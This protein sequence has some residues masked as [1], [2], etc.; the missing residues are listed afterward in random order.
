MTPENPAPI[1]SLS[2]LVVEDNAFAARVLE[3][4]LK[5]L[6]AEHVHLAR[7]GREGL[8]LAA[9]LSPPPDVILLDLRMPEMG[10]VELLTRLGDRRYPG[11][12]IVTSGVDEETLDS[13]D[14][15]ARERS[16]RLLG[17]LQKPV[18][19]ESLSRLLASMPGAEV[20]E[21]R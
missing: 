5:G 8:D 4:T 2:F 17:C 7:T 13:V 18:E 14:K 3:R 10:G 20:P 12:V 16:V 1:A 21:P 11:A 6:G 15:L 9:T 19:A